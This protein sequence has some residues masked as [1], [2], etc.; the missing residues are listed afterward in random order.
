MWM[1][2]SLK[3]SFH[4]SIRII[5]K[6][7]KI[8]T[9]IIQGKI[10]NLEINL[11]NNPVQTV[12]V[13]APERMSAIKIYMDDAPSSV[14]FVQ[15][16]FAK[17]ITWIKSL[18]VKSKVAMKYILP[19]KTM[20]AVYA[21][22]GASLGL[23]AIFHKWLFMDMDRDYYPTGLSPF[24]IQYHAGALKDDILKLRRIL[25]PDDF[26]LL[27]KL[28]VLVKKVLT[29]NEKIRRA[30]VEHP[31]TGFEEWV[32]PVGS[33]TFKT[34][35]LTTV[36]QSSLSIASSWMGWPIIHNQSLTDKL[37]KKAY[38]HEYK[39]RIQTNQKRYDFPTSYSY[40]LFGKTK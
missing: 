14:E 9:L 30:A 6:N 39:V 21:G 32:L 22:I 25:T 26:E 7:N 35:F 31:K 17:V 28:N 40:Q 11:R 10:E 13:V 36:L 24:S 23:F 3:K 38:T 8:R 34:L 37:K 20:F 1:Y 2:V 27:K 16:D 29:E 15:T 12:S 19:S 5:L 33:W 18:T 4:V